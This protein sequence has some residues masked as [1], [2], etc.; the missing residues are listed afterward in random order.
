MSQGTNGR[1]Y[2]I[3]C[4]WIPLNYEKAAIFRRKMNGF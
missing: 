2:P 4:L 3:L 1:L